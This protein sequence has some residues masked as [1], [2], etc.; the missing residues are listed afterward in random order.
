[1]MTPALPKLITCDEFIAWYPNDSKRYELH[2]GVIFEM[3]PPSGDHEDI[4]VF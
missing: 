1:M 3:P 4:V 2:Q